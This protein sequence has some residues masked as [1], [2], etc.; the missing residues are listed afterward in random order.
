MEEWLIKYEVPVRT[1]FFIG[2]FLLF[3]AWERLDVWRIYKGNVRIR[4]YRHLT[5]LTATNALIRIIYPVGTI[6][7]ALQVQEIKIGL[8]NLPES[9]FLP[10]WAKCIVA[11]I[12]FDLIMYVQHRIFH[13]V[14]FLWRFHSMHHTDRALD[15]STGI[16]L[17]PVELIV[18]MGI[19]I[20][21]VAFIGAPVI[22]VV[23]FEIVL[24]MASMF[25]HANLDM[26]RPL[27][28]I[29]RFFIVTP[30][31]HRVH[32]SVILEERDSN[33]GFFF[34][35]WDW[36]LNT[37]THFSRMGERK[38]V[39]GVEEFQDKKYQPIW[40]MLWM[41]FGK[42]ETPYIKKKSNLMRTEE[43]PELNKESQDE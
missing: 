4:W 38:L 15:A 3:L 13:R 30:H 24:N 33:F 34:S 20:L 31:M 43:K 27:E 18:V 2:F 10:F 28:K 5:I 26:P 35:W 32:H 23:I 11:F 39:F 42:F 40:G 37:Y 41:P 1:L 6:A 17:H 21:A 8:L 22:A 7:T 36:I 12:V 9:Q 14:K 16:R 19:K 29:L 25:T